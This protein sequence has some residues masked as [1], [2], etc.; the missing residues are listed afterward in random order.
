MNA[1]TEEQ[2]TPWFPGE[3]EPMM[4]RAG[5][6]ETCYTGTP[7]QGGDVTGYSYW[8]GIAWSMQKPTVEDAYMEGLFGHE[9]A[10]TPDGW[11][12][13]NFDPS[14][15]HGLSTMEGVEVTN[16]EPEEIDLFAEGGEQ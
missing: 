11:R 9:L 14:V 1:Y 13:L 7:E 12:G 16:V 2:L 4:Q 8:G 5:V 3:E 15:A 10:P 6:F